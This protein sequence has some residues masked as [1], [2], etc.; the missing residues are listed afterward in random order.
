MIQRLKT[1]HTETVIPTLIADLGYKNAQEILR[2]KNS[3]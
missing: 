3:N 1:L 2:L